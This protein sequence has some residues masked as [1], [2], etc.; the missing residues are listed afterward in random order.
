MD[1]NLLCINKLWNE[2]D[3]NEKRCYGSD[4]VVFNLFFVDYKNIY[5]YLF[6]VCYIMICGIYSLMKI[7]F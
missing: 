7:F 4:V 5:I 6:N 1:L 2:D 3:Y